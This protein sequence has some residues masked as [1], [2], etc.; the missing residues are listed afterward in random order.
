MIRIISALVSV[1][2]SLGL[3]LILAYMNLTRIDPLAG[4]AVR[5][6]KLYSVKTVLKP[7]SRRPRFKPMKK[8]AAQTPL[9]KPKT[10]SENQPVSANA[11]SDMPVDA[12]TLPSN[13]VAAVAPLNP[14]YPESARQAGIECRL[15]LEVI[16]DESGNVSHAQVA[17]VSRPGYGFEESAVAAIRA[18]R[19]KPVRIQ[20]KVVKV[21]IIYPIDFVLVR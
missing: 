18:M 11:L 17:H 6:M 20:D 15:L 16:I 4:P 13:T 8:M 19:F 3:F 14:K 1:A 9:P 7:V 5:I 10:I 2:V 21:K 12:N